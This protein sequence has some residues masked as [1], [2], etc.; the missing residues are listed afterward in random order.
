MFYQ[1]Q[2]TSRYEALD[3]L[4]G[5]AA[6]G[7]LAT[8]C[9]Q[10]VIPDGTLN[11]TPLRMLV[12]GRS[13][14]IF[15]FVLSGFVLA[16]SIWNQRERFSYL[17]YSASR[18]ARLYPPYLVAGIAGFLIAA[19]AGGAELSALWNYAIASGTKLGRTLNSPSWSLVYEIRL[20]FLMPLVCLVIVR[21][22][23]L[24]IALATALFIAG[25]VALITTGIGQFAYGGETLFE[26]LVTTVHFGISFIIGALLA[27]D[28]RNKRM[29]FTL[30][31]R[32]PV[33]MAGIAYILM[34]VLLDQLSMIGAA[35]LIALAMQLHR[36]EAFLSVPVLQW[37]GRISYSLY[38]T[39]MLLLTGLDLAYKDV[40][41]P[42]VLSIVGF[43]L[44]FAVAE[45]FYW[46][47]E[48]PCIVLSRKVRQFGCGPV[49]QSPT[50]AGSAT[51]VEANSR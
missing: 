14:V 16:T 51:S 27:W 17:N 12:N 5:I 26:A 29:F 11:Y 21:N 13:F 6:V 3:A 37:L 48:K 30:V 34:S 43:L 46:A 10:Q 41:P 44:A 19:V 22:I 47:V 2:Q 23:W 40:V 28:W 24:A 4:R 31:S 38:L 18:I 8:H 49:F 36:L 42:I 15:F 39:H 45:L 20:S 33:L 25:E 32:H 7:V 1:R 50:Q 35:L 9:L